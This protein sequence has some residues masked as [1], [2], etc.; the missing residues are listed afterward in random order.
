MT[1]LPKTKA[2]S[3]FAHHVA[4]CTIA[5]Q[6]TVRAARAAGPDPDRNEAKEI[7]RLT[8]ALID[9]LHRLETLYNEMGGPAVFGTPAEELGMDEVRRLLPE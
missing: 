7:S 8:I 2:M 9:K 3:I 1:A 4:Q 6:R 5:H